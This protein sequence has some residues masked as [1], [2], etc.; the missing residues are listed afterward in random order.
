MGRPLPT[1]TQ[2]LITYSDPLI[3][4]LATGL[5]ATALVVKEIL[6]S[7]RTRFWINICAIVILLIWGILYS[8]A[9]Y[10]PMWSML[11]AMQR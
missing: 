9:A 5:I 3:A 6:A 4:L 7:P 10:L 2:Y 8:F 1:D 11:R